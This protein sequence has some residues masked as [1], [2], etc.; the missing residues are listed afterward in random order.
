MI[1][2]DFQNRESALVSPNRE[3]FAGDRDGLVAA[4]SAYRV[5]TGEIKQDF[6]DALAY[7][8]IGERIGDT[9]TS[10]VIEAIGAPIFELAWDRGH[11]SGYSEVESEYMDIAEIAVTAYALARS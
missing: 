10:K 11:A 4:N 7:E 1:Y 8:Y 9:A 5:A 3:D 2:A 6:A